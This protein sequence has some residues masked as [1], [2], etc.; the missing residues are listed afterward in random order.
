MLAAVTAAADEITAA[1]L[2]S[3]DAPAVS[4]SASTATT[5][6]IEVARRAE[7]AREAARAED[8]DASRPDLAAAVRGAQVRHRGGRP[9][10]RG[11]GEHLAR[12]RRGGAR[13]A[14]AAGRRGS[15]RPARRRVSGH[16][17]TGWING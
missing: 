5:L 6:R 4:P 9:G 13:S 17:I 10:R 15:A 8:A 1:L 3:P 11:V 14:T 16:R 12:A 7:P 2:D